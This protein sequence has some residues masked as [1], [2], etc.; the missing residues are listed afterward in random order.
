M[1][2]QTQVRDV[3]IIG[4]SNV[5]RYLFRA[6][7]HYAQST[8]F[9]VARNQPEFDEAIKLMQPDKYRIVVFAVLTNLVVDAGETAPDQSRRLLA[10]EECLSNFIQSLR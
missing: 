2:C 7:L 8:D 4:D 9:G 3:L 1:S 6:G 5:R 10:I